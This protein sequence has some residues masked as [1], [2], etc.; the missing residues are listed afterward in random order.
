MMTRQPQEQLVVIRTSWRTAK[1]ANQG[2]PW[3]RKYQRMPQIKRVAPAHSTTSS[4]T[5]Q[6]ADG[7]VDRG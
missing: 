7:R 1:V 3:D 5:A 6:A 2:M 4:D